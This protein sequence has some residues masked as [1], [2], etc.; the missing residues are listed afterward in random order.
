M[1]LTSVYEFISSHSRKYPVKLL[2]QTLGISRSSY[3]D[4]DQGN[5][6][7]AQ[8]SQIACHVA[9]M[10][11]NHRRRY[12]SRRISKALKQEGIVVGRYKVRRLMKNQSLRAIQPKSFVPKTTNSKHTLGYAPN[13]L[14]ARDFP[15]APNKVFVGDITYLPTT[16]GQ[17]LYLNIWMDLYSRRIVG[18]KVD[19][20]MDEHLV[21]DSLTQAINNRRPG[22]GLI[23]HSDR[24]GQ[25][26]SALFKATLKG[27]TQSM[28]NA[29]NPY[30]NAFAESFFSRFKAELLEKGAFE[31]IQDATTE[32]FE[33]IEMYYN[34]KRLHSGLN[35]LSPAK[36]EQQ[37]FDQAERNALV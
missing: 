15:Q 29:D 8:D 17:W 22:A 30:D 11:K 27:Q 7:R 16:S 4:Y 6:Y 20:R 14:A 19:F 9:V 3:Y 33:Y 18:W 23:V 28:S 13:V 34:T 36:Y 1:R 21:T 24:G 5:T 32:I 37:Y 31:N 12:G 26:A 10:F 25:Y 2:C 35:Y